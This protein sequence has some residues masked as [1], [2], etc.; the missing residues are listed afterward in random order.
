[1][2]DNALLARPEVGDDKVFIL[3]YRKIIKAIDALQ[4]TFES[5][6]ALVVAKHLPTHR[7]LVSRD[8]ALLMLCDLCDIVECAHELVLCLTCLALNLNA[9]PIILDRRR[10]FKGRMSNGCALAYLH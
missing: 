5:A 7:Y 6:A 8:I 4:N 1:M 9:C 10:S 2:A 3:G